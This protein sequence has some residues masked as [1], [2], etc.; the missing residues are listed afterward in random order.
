MSN[1]KQIT[2]NSRSEC[3]VI[4]QDHA[5]TYTFDAGGRLVG[6]YRDGRNYRRSFSNQILEKADGNPVGIW[7]YPPQA[8]T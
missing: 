7:P 5:L 8:S 6:A 1:G 3:T 2:V 4:M